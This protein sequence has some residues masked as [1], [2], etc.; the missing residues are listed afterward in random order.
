MLMGR[1]ATCA[2][3]P[4]HYIGGQYL[5]RAHK[6][7]PHADPPIVPVPRAEQYRA[8]AML[9]KYVL[10]AGAWNVSP[11]LLQHL[12]YSEW[13]GYG[14]VGFEG[15]GNLPEWAYDPPKRHDFPFAENVARIQKRALDQMLLPSV[16]ARIGDASF[17]STRADPMRLTDLFAWLHD[18]VFREF[19]GTRASAPAN[20]GPLRRA[21]QVTY[22][23]DLV[24][25]YRSPAAG[26]P[27]DAQ[28][29]A[30]AALVT[31]DAETARALRS[32]SLDAA[33]RTHLAWLE[34]RAASALHDER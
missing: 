33:T 10:S 27:A 25:L 32:R 1:Y 13:A 20:V 17:E 14:Y 9:D 24:A 29:L 30:R 18:A 31:L 4:T 6:G 19:A 34:G 8:F 16:L 3:L 11:G 21:L 7:D 2:Q 28:A 23:R 15:Y 5:S 26:T 12:G 22:A